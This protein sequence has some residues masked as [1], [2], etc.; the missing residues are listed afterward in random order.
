MDSWD[1]ICDAEFKILN[2]IARNLGNNTEVRGTI[3]F[4][5]DLDYCPSCRNVMKQFKA[6]YEHV[7]IQVLYKTKGGTKNK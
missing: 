6:K 5:T 1:R 2:E 3:K 4:Y 7:T